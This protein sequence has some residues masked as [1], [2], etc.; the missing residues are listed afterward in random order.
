MKVDTSIGALVGKFMVAADG[1]TAS[2]AP[3][4]FWIPIGDHPLKLE[5]HRED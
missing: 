1:H 3:D 2:N 5:R 4:L